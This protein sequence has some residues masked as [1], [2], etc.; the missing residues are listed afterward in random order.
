MVGP[1]TRPSTRPASGWARLQ[2][3]SPHD[4]STWCAA[5]RPEHMTFSPSILSHLAVDDRE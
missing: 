3:T 2:H 1:R 4:L 5:L